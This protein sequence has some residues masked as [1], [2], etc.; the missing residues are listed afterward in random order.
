MVSSMVEAREGLVGWLVSRY[1]SGRM[2]G[3]SAQRWEVWRGGVRGRKGVEGV[4]LARVTTFY[5]FKLS[6]GTFTQT[7]T[8]RQLD[9]HLDNKTD[10]QTSDRR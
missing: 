4:F 1:F 2:G 10:T 6:E 3:G 7:Q 9:R 8:V 5:D